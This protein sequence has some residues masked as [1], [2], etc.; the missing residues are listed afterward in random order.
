MIAAPDRP[1]IIAQLTDLHLTSGPGRRT[2]GT[3]VWAN[4][5]RV[6]A[7]LERT[8]PDLV[9]LTGDIANIGNRRTYT[10]LRELLAPWIERLYIVPGNHDS[11]EP[12]RNAFPTRLRDDLEGAGFVTHLAGFDL[13][14]L[15]SH[16]EGRVH[17]RLGEAQLGWLE[18]TL[19]G[20]SNPVIL[21]QHHPPVLIN[22]WW[23]DKDLLRDVDRLRD[24]VRGSAVRAIFCGHVHQERRDRFAGADV[25]LT[26]ST[27]YQFEPNARWPAKIASRSPAYRLIE[28]SR[29]RVDARI[30][31]L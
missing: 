31:R 4:L 25:W 13:I 20:S 29:G 23:L 28:L 21:F 27:A 24:V 22:C 3:D 15:D 11:R 26:S 19:A 14:G 30:V 2:R 12:L 18:D 6:L 5:D 10:R 16:R 17:G 9:V 8:S 1:A 7:D